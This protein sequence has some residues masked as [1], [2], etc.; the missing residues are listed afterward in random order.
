MIVN[1]RRVLGTALF[2]ASGFNPAFG[3]YATQ[4]L[5]VVVPTAPG[6]PIDIATRL[7][8]EKAYASGGGP[9]VVDNKPGA[10]LQIGEGFVAKSAANGRT[11]VTTTIGHFIN[12]VMY[13]NMAYDPLKD[14]RPVFLLAHID[15]LLVASAQI[16]PSTIKEVIAWSKVNPERMTFASGGNGSGGHLIATMIASAAALPMNHVPYK[17]V[18]TYVTDLV[19][20]RV[21]FAIGTVQEMTPLIQAGKVKG[22]ATTARRRNPNLPE[23]PTLAESGLPELGMT[24]WLTV[25][26]PSATPTPIV[27][28]IANRLGKA[29]TSP[30]VTAGLAKYGMRGEAMTLAQL[31]SFMQYEAQLWA[32]AARA[33]N[34]KPE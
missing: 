10:N 9:V 28:E 13:A 6:G 16:E 1:R 22:I 31:E 8:F 15:V 20:G 12:P 2:A 26:A 27:L 32:N 24:S 33:A 5:K 19:A 11:L 17:S 21:S 25:F 14:L 3:Q 34:L 4:P 18:A 7:L 30:E 23:V 29:L